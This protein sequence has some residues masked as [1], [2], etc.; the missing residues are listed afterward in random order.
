MNVSRIEYDSILYAMVVRNESCSNGAHF[1]TDGSGL[2]EVGF[3]SH[4]RGAKLAEHYHLPYQRETQGTNEVLFLKSGA[5]RCFFYGQDHSLKGSID[6]ME[7]D[8]ILL[9]DGGHGFEMLEDS[10]LIEVKNGPY[11][12]AKDKVWFDQ[13]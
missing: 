11:A 9:I 7:G 10:V 12:G 8:L 4:T 2:L 13:L 5:V 3:L 6:L 1:I